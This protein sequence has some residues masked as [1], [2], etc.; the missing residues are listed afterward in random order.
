MFAY[1]RVNHLRSSYSMTFFPHGNL[2]SNPCRVHATGIQL[3]HARSLEDPACH[4]TCSHTVRPSWDILGHCAESGKCHICHLAATDI[5]VC[6]FVSS[7]IT[8]QFWSSSLGANGRSLHCRES[9]ISWIVSRHKL[10]PSALPG[11]MSRMTVFME[12]LMMASLGGSS[13]H[14]SHSHQGSFRPRGTMAR[15]WE[16]TVAP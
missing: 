3:H 5:W 7:P 13:N 15:L 9:W 11:G 4:L 16:V 10:L 14:S 12:T 6:A 2:P 1:Q 8:D